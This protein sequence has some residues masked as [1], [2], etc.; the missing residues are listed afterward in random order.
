VAN[1]VQTTARDVRAAKEARQLDRVDPDF[2]DPGLA[3]EVAQIEDLEAKSHAARTRDTYRRE[4]DAFE[5][6]CADHNFRSLPASINTL[7]L[8]LKQ[9]ALGPTE[10]TT[11]G[12][13][14]RSIR[15]AIAAIAHEHHV[16][17]LISPH[18]HPK[19]AKLLK[20]IRNL[21]GVAA[22]KKAPVEVP[23]LHR[24]IAGID[25]DPAKPPTWP[26]AKWPKTQ[27][28][29]RR[30]VERH[31]HTRAKWLHGRELLA[32]RDKALLALGF[33]AALR[34]SE[35][36]ALNVEHIKFV[37]QGLE[38]YIAG[39]KGDQAR[40]GMTMYIPKAKGSVCPC[41]LLREWLEVS[42]LRDGGLFLSVTQWGE[43]GARL[44]GE[45]VARVVKKR[46]RRAW[47]GRHL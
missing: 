20:G 26:R 3:S 21:K 23:L 12:R 6:W 4:F 8:Y 13:K 19:L 35:I 1:L 2:E 25:A 29:R 32:K 28:A 7:K 40:Q 10:R 43:L 47:V 16:H 5:A 18:A 34:R 33:A 22:H 41:A 42:E 30:I 14:P 45:D 17:N 37:E 9:L 46:A 31:E 36:V 39:S 24:L 27:A 44:S 38:L 11:S 15:V